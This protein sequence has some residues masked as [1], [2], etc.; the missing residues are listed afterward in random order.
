M[1]ITGRNSNTSIVGLGGAGTNA[2]EAIVRRWRVTSGEIRKALAGL[3]DPRV[4]ADLQRLIDAHWTGK[5]TEPAPLPDER[6]Q[7][8]AA[9]IETL[10]QQFDG[11]QACAAEIRLVVHK[12][13]EPGTEPASGPRRGSKPAVDAEEDETIRDL[14]Q[15]LAVSGDSIADVAN[16][17]ER[18]GDDVDPEGRELLQEEVRALEMDIAVLKAVM[19]DPVD[20]ERELKRLLAEGV[21]PFEGDDRGDEDS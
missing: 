4:R 1:S 21:P 15:L 9:M 11:E 8:L 12:R 10:L 7:A 16:A 2:L 3:R 17:L 14:R 19:A 13:D 5:A 18:R 6:S 20:W